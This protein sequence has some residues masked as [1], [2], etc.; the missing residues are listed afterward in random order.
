MIIRR[1][2][3]LFTA[4]I[5]VSGLSIGV[6]SV[7]RAG[8]LDVQGASLSWDDS[9]FYMPTG[10]SRFKFNWANN[11]GRRLLKLG[12]TMTDPFGD[13]VAWDSK[14]GIESGTSG[15]FDEQ[16]CRHQLENGLG[17]YTVTLTIEDYTSMGAG[18]FAASGQLNFIPRPG[19]APAPSET[20]KRPGASGAAQVRC[21]NRNTFVVKTFKRKAC[22]RGWVKR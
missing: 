10:C 14:I 11:T 16:I 9:T 8:Q 6:S 13:S 17:P 21:V 5:M 1:A 12:F 15:F 3:S 22:P 20:A 18:A 2:L 4:V 7:A 19:S